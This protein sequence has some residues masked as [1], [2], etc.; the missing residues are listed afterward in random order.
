MLKSLQHKFET[1]PI[2]HQAYLSF[3]KEY[4]DLQHM[5]KVPDEE[6]EPKPVFYLPHHGVIREF[7]SKTKLRVVFNGSCE[8]LHT[9]TKLQAN[10]FDVLIWFRRHKYIFKY[11]FDE[12]NK[13]P[14][15][16]DTLTQVLYADD[17]F[18]GAI[19]VEEAQQ[20][21][22][23]VHQLCMAGDFP[24]KKWV[25]N[26]P[27][28]LEFIPPEHGVTTT[29]IQIKDN[30]VHTLGLSWNL[31]CDN[32]QFDLSPSTAAEITK[33]LVLSKIAEFFD[34]LGLLPPLLIQ[35][36]IFMPEL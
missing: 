19:T 22:Y 25:N 3:I 20:T 34:P 9:G 17:V 13:F 23:Q 36:K 35:F 2:Y 27:E 29:S 33:C 28:I 7:S 8:I 5:I 12:G 32:L 26:Q 14:L 31:S 24:L 30:I 21:A 15:A 10:L 18:G 16:V 1:N 11:I 4:Q 6:V